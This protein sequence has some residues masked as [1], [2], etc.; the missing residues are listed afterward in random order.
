MAASLAGSLAG[1]IFL[2]WVVG[3]AALVSF[4]ALQTVA[5]YSVAHPHFAVQNWHVFVSYLACTWLCCLTVLFANKALP[6][7]E[8]WGGFFIIVG[9]TVS[10]ITCA[11]MPHVN[12][13]PYAS[14]VSVWREWTN[15]TGWSST[16]FV[17]GLGLMNAAFAVCAPDIPCHLAEEIPRYCPHSILAQ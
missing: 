16:P 2:A 1:G 4:M 17:F 13:A 15:S 14:H 3:V 7:I 6:I 8:S 9:F 12:G 11:V 10:V 5:M